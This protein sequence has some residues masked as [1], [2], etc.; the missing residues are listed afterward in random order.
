MIRFMLVLVVLASMVMADEIFLNRDGQETQVRIVQDNF[1][2]RDV[3]SVVLECNVRSI[4]ATEI[5]TSAGTFT[6]LSVPGWQ[7]SNNPGSP[8][9]PVLC[10][11]VQV[12]VGG[13]VSIRVVSAQ[14]IE[15]NTREYGIAH[16]VYPNQPS[17]R[18]DQKEVPFVYDRGAYNQ[19][20]SNPIVAVEELGMLRDSRLVLVHFTPVEYSPVDG[21]IAFY[22]NIQAEVV[23]EN[24]DM[25]ATMELKKSASPFFQNSQILTPA[26]LQV[27][28]FERGLGYLIVAHKMFEGNALLQQFVAY[29]KSIGYNVV[30]KFV[31]N[32]TVESV[33]A[34]VKAE[35]EASKPTFFLIVGDHAQVPGKSVGQYTDLYYVSTLVGGTAD[36]L[37]DMLHGRFSASTVAELEPQIT[38]TLA[39]EKREFDA[40]FLKRYALVA[41]WDGSWAVKRGYPQIRYAFKYY[42]NESKGYVKPVETGTGLD[43]NIFL[44]TK[45]GDSP[46]Q[47]VA[48]INSGVGFFNYTAHGSQTDFSDPNFTMGDIDSLNNFNMYPVVIGNCCLTGSFQQPTCFG[49]K[50]LRVAN[51]G[52]IG[53]IGGS[54]YTYWDEDLWFGVGNCQ[55]TTEINA[56]Q[57]PIKEQTTDGMYEAGFGIFGNTMNLKVA[58]NSAIMLAGNLAV[59][60]S[61]SSRKKYYFEVYHLFGDPSLPCY[62]ALK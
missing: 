23:V 51:K 5:Q 14:K 54:N 18:K 49:E 60:A 2:S 42:F 33:Q 48:L 17:L 43:R 8:E 34:L 57:S 28:S 40:N 21:Q 36:Y 15:G 19:R 53:F 24:A 62:W 1:N 9:L 56:G 55:L 61:T 44:T 4:E 3:A 6:R 30:I 20:S 12:P 59:N 37:P 39:Y 58:C 7:F 50:W 26:S 32:A 38:K 35:Y 45:S 52:A 41:G 13:E 27:S 22:S 47:I 46:K 16:Q 25:Q 31:E 29:K 11:L 10:K